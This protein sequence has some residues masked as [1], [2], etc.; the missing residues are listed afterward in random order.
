MGD[1]EDDVWK[2]K[3]IYSKKIKYKKALGYTHICH[4]FKLKNLN[5]MLKYKDEMLVFYYFSIDPW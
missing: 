1:F 3:D 2:N 4:I 5:G